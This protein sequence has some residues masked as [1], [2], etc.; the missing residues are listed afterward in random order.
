MSPFYTWSAAT[1]GDSYVGDDAT[2]GVSEPFNVL[3][4]GA[5]YYSGALAGVGPWSANG[6][7]SARRVNGAGSLSSVSA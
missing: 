7:S 6:S 2:V 1:N 3:F 5:S 4:Y